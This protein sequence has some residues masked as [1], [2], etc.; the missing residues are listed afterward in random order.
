MK[1]LNVLIVDDQVLF[2]EGFISLL[3]TMP[4]IVNVVGVASDGREAFE[5]ARLINPDLIFMDICM[6]QC[7]GLEATWLI[8]EQMPEVK[9]VML[10][11]SDHS[12]DL[13]E[14]IKAGAQGYL[15]KNLNTNQLFEILHGVMRGEA[16][17]SPNTAAKILKEFRK[18]SLQDQAWDQQPTPQLSKRELEVLKLVVEG[19]SNRDIAATLFISE[20]TVKNHLRSILDTLHVQN[21]VQAAVTA[22]RKGLIPG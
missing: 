22:V 15:L 18:R 9:I 21:R 5:K 13:F 8:K 11:V 20:S 7:N 4:E 3:K 17:M 6:P 1:P 14:A 19:A 2:R 10:T 12:D 16:P